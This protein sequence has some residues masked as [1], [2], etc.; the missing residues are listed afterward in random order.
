MNSLKQKVELSKI[1]EYIEIN[2]DKSE[3]NNILDKYH[4][5][6]KAHVIG[7]TGPPGVGKSS[8]INCLIKIIR[9]NN[10]TVGVIAVDPSSRKSGG[11]LLGDRARFSVDPKDHKIFIRSLAAKD[12]LG[13]IS[14]MTYPCISVMRSFFDILI[15]ET[16]GVGQSEISVEDVADSVIFCVQPGSGDTLQFMKSGIIEIPDIICVTKSDL[17][18]LSN[19]TIA[20]LKSSIKY[21]NSSDD[22]PIE[23]VSISSEK[24]IGIEKL[25][26]LLQ[27]RWRRLKEKNILEKK[28]H[29]QEKLWI[30][31]KIKEKIGQKGFKLTKRLKVYKLRPYKFCENIL[32]KIKIILS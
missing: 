10:N 12:S 19:N 16:V 32:N 5:R 29:N 9:S 27:E 11:A 25:S 2:K 14:E 22:W 13:G 17:S 30:E 7:I 6:P 8:L 24:K 1:L 23:I 21:L 15:V 4:A 20:D 18:D 31:K 26:E 3:T 28:R